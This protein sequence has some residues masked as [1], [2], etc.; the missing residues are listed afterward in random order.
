METKGRLT[1]PGGVHPAENKHLSEAAAIQVVPNP[2]QVAV[3]LSQHI[4][5]GCSALVAKRDKVQ[6]GQM[7]GDACNRI[8]WL[9]GRWPS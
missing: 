2:K 4:G 3:L 9:A 5:A 1:F 6:A 8:L 7:I